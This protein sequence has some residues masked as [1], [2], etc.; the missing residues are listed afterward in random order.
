MHG[1]TLLPAEL[2]EA[3]TRGVTILTG[4][5]RAARTLRQ[6][7][8]LRNR[9]R[10]LTH[11]EPPAVLAWDSW[12]ASLW[13]RLLIDG[14]A[15]RLLL[16]R[17]QEHTLWRMI[18][19]ADPEGST[20]RTADALA[21][22]AA[23]AYSRLAAY[24]GEHRLRT[25]GISADTRAF[26]RW[27]QAFERLC[28]IE[29][30]LPQAQLEA[31]LIAAVA[32]GQISPPAEGYLLA[33][34]DRT[35]PAQQA[36]IDAVRGAGCPITAFTLAS[37]AR[38]LHLVTATD[39]RDELHAAANW[40]RRHLE[41]N[42]AAR[43][44]LIVPS[45][46]DHRTTI[47]RVLR[48]TLAPELEDITAPQTPAPFEF[49]LGMPLAQA[50]IVATALD[51][52]RWTIQPL[53]TVRI[54][55]LLLSPYL[56]ASPA[57]INAR[58]EFD[59]YE[60]RR[61][62]TLRPELTLD[63]MLRQTESA[64]RSSRLPRLIAALKAM[65]RAVTSEA[66]TTADLRPAADWADAI[67][68]LLEAAGW[69]ASSDDSIE[70]QTRRKWE[71]VLD[72]LATLDFQ[73]A[74]FT[75]PDTLE[76]LARLAQQTL[77]APESRGAA[78]QVLGPLESAGSTF[79]AI[80]FLNAGDLSWPVHSGSNPLLAWHLQRDLGMPGTDP[81]EDIAQVRRITGRV[82]S[83]APTVVFSYAQQ[84]AT[85][86]QRPSSALAGLRL[87]PLIVPP[88][89]SPQAFL[90]LE[91]ID[92][93]PNLPQLPD[94][95]I[96]GGA[97]ILKLQAACGFRAF[98]EQ[99]LWATALDTT[100]AGIDARENG[101]IIHVVLQHFWDQVHDQ[102]T[103][104]GLTAENRRQLLATAIDA[105][106]HKVEAAAISTW[107]AAFLAIQRE[108]LLALLD[109]WLLA[110]LGREVPFTVSRQETEL[111]DVTI[112]PLRLP[113][114]VARIDATAHG[115]VILDYKTGKPNV[116]DWLSDRPDE[117]QLPLYAVLAGAR[118]LAGV[119]FAQIRPGK[120][121]SL[122][123]YETEPGILLK[124]SSLSRPLEIQLEDWN[125]VLTELAT[126]FHDG[127]IRVRPKKYPNT[128]AFCAQRILCRL[129]LS[130]L[131]Q[132]E[133]E[134]DQD[135]DSDAETDDV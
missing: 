33:G 5:Q 45:L 127:D 68:A 118:D 38:A 10:N 74:R 28:R 92:D 134:A 85:G 14:H 96:R 121:M 64:K 51:L 35:T 22:M 60:L 133:D 82:A 16:N 24:R 126:S 86:H 108:R 71:S 21:E 135:Y 117:P 110:E 1:S 9:A 54:S 111:T 79:D 91:A 13:Q 6:Q 125:R 124:P 115:D 57:E 132:P 26:Q 93:S 70:F 58:A 105:A 112:G 100:E 120:D 106:L 52:L 43:I 8:D 123:G 65:R 63:A 69:S 4:N 73:G 84:S 27:A 39:E 31:A 102:V 98:A 101:T 17:P 40:M 61:I 48:H 129:D 72:E 44:A 83:S 89:A 104:R 97:Q 29:N 42:P 78:V 18:I 80:W 53:P 59:A 114:S 87:E 50:P 95:V 77:F 94:Q 37:P 99:R 36:L 88:I 3:L 20:L 11:W 56:A 109:S 131:D 107:D 81:A 113:H 12:I 30:Y 2:V 116:A 119:A 23:D 47:D 128:C 19:A 55:Q 66:L 41:A 25:A 49:S 67:R 90:T 76:A 46:G 103:L 62:R 130:V 15:T 122:Y 7:V 34:F 75:F 32:A